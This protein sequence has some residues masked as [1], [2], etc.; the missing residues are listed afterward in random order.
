LQAQ[1]DEN[2]RLTQYLNEVIKE[3]EEKAPL[4]KRQ[5]HEYDEAIK[6]VANLTAQLENAMMDYEVLKAKSEDAIK[7]HNTV[8]SENMRLKQD[9]ADLSRQVTVL[10]YEVEQLRAKI[11]SNNQSRA[12]G[13]EPLNAYYNAD[14]TLANLF[15]YNNEDNVNAS[16][17]E[18]SSSSEAA[19][20]AAASAGG[21]KS[22]ILFRNIEEMQ[23][24]NQRL[25]RMMNEISD[26]RD[27]EERSELEQRTRDY[28][29][30]LTLALRELDEM[31]NQRE[32]QEHILEEIRKQ[33]DTYKSLLNSQK[34]HQVSSSSAITA[35][36]SFFT[37]TPGG[38]QRMKMLTARQPSD[39]FM[40]TQNDQLLQQ[41]RLAETS[42][43]ELEKLQ[44]QFERYQ[45]EMLKTNK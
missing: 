42:A 21:N 26:K 37:S 14:S 33:R 10:V 29:E 20:A 2:E 7:K 16:F 1:K 12:K 24:Q 3:V 31:R 30:K 25:V 40:D 36:T 27:A 8:S 38:D 41:Q 15:G 17:A 22:A 45:E 4:I 5:K 34:D 43:Q 18:V 39:Q 6:T 23:R 13:V 32:K 11:V 44:K 9:V 28:T 35:T 19:A